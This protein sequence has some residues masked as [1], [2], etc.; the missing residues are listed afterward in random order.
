MSAPHVNAIINVMRTLHTFQRIGWRKQPASE[1]QE[2]SESARAGVVWIT[3]PHSTCIAIGHA[4]PTL[5]RPVH[6]YVVAR[7]NVTS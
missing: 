6:N 5:S 2:L 4:W 3:E 7:V 1:A